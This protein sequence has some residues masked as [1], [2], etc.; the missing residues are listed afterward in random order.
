M[1]Q[2][3][4]QNILYTQTQIINMAVQCLNFF[5]KSGFKWIDPKEFYSNK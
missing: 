5:S 4:N 2:N 1:T 3:K